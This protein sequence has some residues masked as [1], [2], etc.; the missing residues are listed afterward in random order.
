[1]KISFI[2]M[3]SGFGSRFGSNKLMS[4]LG[5]KELYRYGLECLCKGASALREDGHDIEILVVSQYEQIL[6]QARCLGLGSVPNGFSAEGI[7][8]SLR[9]G[10]G[11]SREGTE[12]YLFCVADQPYMRTSTLVSFVCGFADSGLGIGCVCHHGKRGNPAVFRSRYRDDLLSLTGDRGGSVIMKAH[13]EDVWTMEVPKEELKD[14][15]RTADLE[16]SSTV[17]SGCLSK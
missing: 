3:A 11:A 16:H 7:T 13:P 2:Y 9:L 4:L 8:A 10:T 12:G 17:L 6:D 1:M 5:G 14:I 15:D